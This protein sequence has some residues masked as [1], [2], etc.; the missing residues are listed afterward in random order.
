MALAEVVVD[1]LATV[2][3]RSLAPRG[4]CPRA[5]LTRWDCH[6]HVQLCQL[7]RSALPI[8][9]SVRRQG[10]VYSGQGKLIY[11]I[12]LPLIWKIK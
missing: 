11:F 6:L 1:Q 2:L 5:K 12:L 8:A 4:P 3:C 10:I 7:S 9:T